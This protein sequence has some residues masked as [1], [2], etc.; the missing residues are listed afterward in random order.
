M[1]FEAHTQVFNTQPLVGLSRIRS[2]LLPMQ[3]LSVKMRRGGSMALPSDPWPSL[4][5]LEPTYQLFLLRLCA[6]PAAVV[7]EQHFGTHRC[8]KC[9]GSITSFSESTVLKPSY[10][11][12]WV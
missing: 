12:S 4:F 5:F 11:G 3:W 8:L 6:T 10:R 1:S 2:S 9:V 7:A